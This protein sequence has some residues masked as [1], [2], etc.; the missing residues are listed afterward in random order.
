MPIQHIDK[1]SALPVADEYAVIINCGTK[2][3]TTLA[4]LSALRHAAMPVLLIDCESCDGSRA[5]FETLAQQNEL[6]FHFLAWPL[7]PHPQ[8][9]DELFA[10]IPATKVLLV[11]SDVEILKK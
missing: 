6:S 8:A 7:R 11:D 1:L 9:L 10:N 3:V 2:W 5:H 4:L